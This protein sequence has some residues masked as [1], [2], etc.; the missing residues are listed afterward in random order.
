MYGMPT[1]QSNAIQIESLMC[2]PTE[3]IEVRFNCHCDVFMKNKLAIVGIIV[4]FIIICRGRFCT[5]FNR[6]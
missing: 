1:N 6:S 5:I 3:N 2:N 4:L